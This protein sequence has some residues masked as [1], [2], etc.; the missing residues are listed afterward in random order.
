MVFIAQIH[1]SERALEELQILVC[2]TRIYFC[3]LLLFTAIIF[4]DLNCLVQTI[5]KFHCTVLT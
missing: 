2:T 5:L 4:P 3:T 1:L